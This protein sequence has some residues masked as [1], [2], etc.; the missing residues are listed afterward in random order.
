MNQD[1]TIQFKVRISIHHKIMLYVGLLVLAAVGTTT[2]IAAKIETEVLIDELTHYSKHRAEHITSSTTRAFSSLNWVGVEKMLHEV[3]E[4]ERE[5][6]LYAKI[7]KP[8][9]EV[10]LASQ[11]KYYG[12]TID[13][14][15]LYDKE[16]VLDN[17]HF[18]HTD[19]YGIL[20]VHPFKIG[21]DL[22]RVILG[23]STR[24]IQQATKKLIARN[25]V[26]GG[27]IT[28]LG[29][30]GAFLLSKSISRPIIA[31]ASAAKVVSQGKV[32]LV[33]QLNPGT[34]WAFLIIVLI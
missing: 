16:T 29:L 1:K 17:Y 32:F 4:C 10:Y 26:Y 22:W 11:K 13:P 20:L 34:R 3:T 27:L 31:I 6:L 25:L 28:L 2:Y 18:S 5:D 9:G 24:P 8:N 14:A 21:G 12:D 7:I 23:V 30:V 19:E 33:S 15:L